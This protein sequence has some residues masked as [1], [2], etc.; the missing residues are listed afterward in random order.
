MWDWNEFVFYMG[1]T[2]PDTTDDLF[3]PP[4]TQAVACAVE[5]PTAPRCPKKRVTFT[6]VEVREYAP[7][8]GDSPCCRDRLPISLDWAFACRPIMELGPLHPSNHDDD[9]E[10]GRRTTSTTATAMLVSAAVTTES[11]GT[12]IPHPY[13]RILG[14]EGDGGVGLGV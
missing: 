10:Q 13:R 14:K 11:L 5:P 6:T 3:V 8:V 12:F 9:T 4:P 1:E 7:V 2:I